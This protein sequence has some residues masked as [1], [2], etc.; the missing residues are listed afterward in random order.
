MPTFADKALSFYGGLR[1]P[2]GLPAGVE[3]L[4]P[5]VLPEVRGYMEA[6]LEK[7]FSDAWERIFV[8]GINPGRFGAGLTGVTFTDPLALADYCGIPNDL[9]RRR[10]LSSEFVYRFIEEW[11]GAEK[12]YADFFLTAVS[13]L[14]FTREGVNYNYYDDRVLLD[15]LRPFIHRTLAA[16]LDIGARRDAA[17]VLGTGKNMA[18]FEEL[19]REHGFFRKLIPL[20]HPRFIMQYRRKRIGEYVEK[21]RTA[22]E[23]ALG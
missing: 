11:G 12:F 8:F 16:Q 6:F 15:A 3:M 21:Y 22:F 19:N 5:Y 13:P 2:A 4:N 7:Y 14:G 18:F 23:E 20:E 9:D 17:I 10:E 1:P